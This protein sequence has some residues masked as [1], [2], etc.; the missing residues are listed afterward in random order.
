MSERLAP[1]ATMT[2]LVVDDNPVNVDL[3]KSLLKVE[4]LPRVICETDARRVATILPLVNPDL[5]LLDL[6]MPHLDGYEVLD[7][8]RDFAAGTYLPVLVV[9]ADVAPESR[10]RALAHGARDFLTKPLDVTEITLRIAN[11]LQTRQLYADLRRTV[12]TN[13]ANGS[14]DQPLVRDIIQT[15]IDGRRV[16]PFFQPVVDIRDHGTVGYEALARFAQPSTRGPA[17]W[18]HDAHLV[19][20][21]VNLEWL[22]VMQALPFIDAIPADCFMALN[23]SP[24]T[25]LHLQHEEL[26]PAEVCPQIVIELT[27]HVPVE[28]YAALHFALAG[29]RENG[30]RL[31]A[32]DLGAGYA[33]FRH[34][35]ALEP[36]IIKLDIS[37][38]NG[39][40]ANRPARALA[41]AIVAFAADVGAEVIAEGV[42]AA[43][44]LDELRDLEIRW[45]QGCLLGR[46]A[47]LPHNGVLTA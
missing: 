10:N 17:G 44:D 47:P 31:A 25:I 30:A 18:F 21:G 29:I 7:A 35:L 19:G 46:P 37:L 1:F 15:V 8:I 40:H 3:L 6:H 24:A 11:L 2:V 28:D 39:I 22:A 20:L 14:L 16:A 42:E 36:D 43:A 45:A 9:T 4:G 26:C 13:G 34:L 38:V 33:G 5:I 32:D 27:E 12:G 23:M 41:R